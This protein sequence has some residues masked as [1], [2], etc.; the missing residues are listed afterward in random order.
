[1]LTREVVK[2]FASLAALSV[3]MLGYHVPHLAPISLTCRIILPVACISLPYNS[4][5][6]FIGSF[7][8]FE[9][10]ECLSARPSYFL[11]TTVLEANQLIPLRRTHKK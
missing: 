2:A 7:R 4:M 5:N 3:N 8:L 10:R 9:I 1:M 11:G 6:A